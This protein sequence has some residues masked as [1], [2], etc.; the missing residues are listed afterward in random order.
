MTTADLIELDEMIVFLNE[1]LPCPKSV[2]YR[3]G[4]YAEITFSL[5]YESKPTPREVWIKL[6]NEAL[7]PLL[8]RIEDDYTEVMRA[9]YP[10]AG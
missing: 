5:G 7:T 1:N 6:N 2:K 3:T 10:D 8:P 4:F 9:L